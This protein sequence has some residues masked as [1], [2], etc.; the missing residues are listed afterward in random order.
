MVEANGKTIAEEA[1]EASD[2]AFAWNM[3]TNGR[4]TRAALA[5]L[6]FALASVIALAQSNNNKPAAGP[7]PFLAFEGK[8]SD[9]TIMNNDFHR[10]DKVFT[11]EDER[12]KDE[13]RM[14]NNMSK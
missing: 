13:V 7:V 4:Q 14:L 5:S 11:V 9:V 1:V 3:Q 6:V 10:L 12:C 2:V 8:V